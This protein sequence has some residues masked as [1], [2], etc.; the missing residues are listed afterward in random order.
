MYSFIYLQFFL[1][2]LSSS[3]IDMITIKESYEKLFGKTLLQAI[4]GDTGGHYKHSLV[5]LIGER[6]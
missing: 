6:S 3:Q 2:V 5:A 1:C 4:K